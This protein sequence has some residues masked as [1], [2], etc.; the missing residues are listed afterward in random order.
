MSGKRKYKLN[1]NC[2]S[3]LSP[4]M[5]Y[6]LGFITAD[7]NLLEHQRALYLSIYLSNKDANHMIKFRR[8]CGSSH[9]FY[10]NKRK[11]TFCFRFHSKRIFNDIVNYGIVPR[12]SNVKH[13]FISKIPDQ[14]KHCFIAGLFDGDGTVIRRIKKQNQ[15]KKTYYY[16]YCEVR[17]LSNNNTMKDISKYLSNNF[18]FKNTK[19]KPAYK[20]LL[21]KLTF[22]SKNDLLEFY[23]LYSLSPIHLERKWFRLSSYLI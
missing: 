11:K 19:I 17:I 21:Y 8:F 20:N 9:P 10:F 22:S 2:F 12:K 15:H 3:T 1:E 6:W 4:E 5:Y 23:K 14:Y 13:S 16:D 7:G 18:N